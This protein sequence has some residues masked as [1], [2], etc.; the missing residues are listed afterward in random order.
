MFPSYGQYLPPQHLLYFFLFK[1][2]LKYVLC[3]KEL[4]LVLKVP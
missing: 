4:V 2:A 1:Y 3:E